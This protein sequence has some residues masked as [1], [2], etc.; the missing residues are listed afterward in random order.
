MSLTFTP[1]LSQGVWSALGEVSSFPLGS[2][3]RRAGEGVRKISLWLI[4]LLIVVCLQPLCLK[5]YH[6]LLISPYTLTGEGSEA[7]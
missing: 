4:S 1:L 7:H 6:G 3:G 5:T 2:A